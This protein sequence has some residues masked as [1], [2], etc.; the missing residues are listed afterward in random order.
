MGPLHD[1]LPTLVNAIEAFGLLGQLFGNIPTHKHCLQV[2]PEVLDQQPLLQHLVGVGEVLDPLLDLLL[3]GCIVA[4]GEQGAE[5]H[6][7]VLHLVDR[8]R[9]C[10]ATE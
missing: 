4:V 3:E 9:G 6:E 7:A 5:D 2:D 1:L 8:L 10:V